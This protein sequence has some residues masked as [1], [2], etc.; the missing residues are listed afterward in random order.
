MVEERLGLLYRVQ[1]PLF[2]GIVGFGFAGFHVENIDE[3]LFGSAGMVR[4]K[5]AKIGFY[6]AVYIS[7][8]HAVE[9][10]QHSQF[11]KCY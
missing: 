10:P 1:N 11:C 7:G 5:P 4:P 8:E 6:V 2:C 3:K 9:N